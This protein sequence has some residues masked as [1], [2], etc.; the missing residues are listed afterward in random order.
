MKPSKTKEQAHHLAQNLADFIGSDGRLYQAHYQ[1]ALLDRLM[2]AVDEL[3]PSA[4]GT[5]APAGFAD[6]QS[7]VKDVLLKRLTPTDRE[8]FKKLY[9]PKLQRRK[10]FASD[11]EALAAA[12]ILRTMLDHPDYETLQ[13]NYGAR[14]DIEKAISTI[15]GQTHY[16]APTGLAT[17]SDFIADVLNNRV[18]NEVRAKVLARLRMQRSRAKRD[19]VSL[20]VGADTLAKLQEWQRQHLLHRGGG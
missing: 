16:P 20:E 5:G 18:G 3:G 2:I 14:Y 12:T 1:G 6:W 13:W 15:S 19:L 10:R 7:F 8:K 17:W 11:A 9:A 4:I